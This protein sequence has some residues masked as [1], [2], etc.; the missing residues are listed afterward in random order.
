MF[1]TAGDFG[2]LGIAGNAPGVGGPKRLDGHDHS[3]TMAARKPTPIPKGVADATLPPSMNVPA[4]Q[5]NKQVKEPTPA[6]NG[7]G[8]GY[9]VHFVY[10]EW[11]GHSKKAKPA[12]MELT[13]NNTVKSSSGKSVKFVMTPDT[14]EL[15]KSM[16]V[17]G[18]PTYKVKDL[19]TGTI[20]D[21]NA[22]DRSKEA[23]MTEAA[24]L[25]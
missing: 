20:S 15:A 16:K 8:S 24:K 9:E 3:E 13:K 6:M 25:A 4:S 23:I 22:G 12:M 18:Y 14:T 10:A 2:P 1:A 7:G 11:C 19:S 5:M 17:R 21:F